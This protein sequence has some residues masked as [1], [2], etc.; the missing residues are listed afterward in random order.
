MEAYIKRAY[1]DSDDDAAK[2]D[3]AQ[4]DQL[5]YATEISLLFLLV[6]TQGLSAQ[7]GTFF[8]IPVYFI[9]EV[10]CLILKALHDQDRRKMYFIDGFTM[11]LIISTICLSI[12]HSKIKVKQCN[13]HTVAQNEDLDSF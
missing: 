10:A 1:F 9:G 4:T 8:M 7:Q 2:Q 12:H 3:S 5:R 11:P 6:Q 13:N